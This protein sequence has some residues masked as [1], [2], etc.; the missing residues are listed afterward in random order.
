MTTFN[1]IPFLFL[2]CFL[3]R[4]FPSLGIQKLHSLIVGGGSASKADPVTFGA[5]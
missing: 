2:S 1:V 3:F 5:L 4:L